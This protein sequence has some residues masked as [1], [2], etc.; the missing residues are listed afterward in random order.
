MFGG[1]GGGWA[2]YGTTLVWLVAAAVLPFGGVRAWAAGLRSAGKGGKQVV[3]YVFPRDR[4]LGSEEVSATGLTRVNYAFANIRDG[5][6]VEGFANDGANYA[7][8]RAL[9]KK[10]PALEV[11]PSVGGW[12]WSGQFSDVALTRES[13]AKFID[14]VV[15]FL[16]RYG[17]D[18][19]DI[20]WEYPGQ[21]GAGNVFRPEDKHN[22]TLLLR[23]L[24][25]RFEVEGRRRHRRHLIL[26]IATGSGPSWLENTEMRE[27]QRYVDSIN[28]MTYDMYGP[29]DKTTGHDSP[30]FVNPAD[31]KGERADAVDRS[32]KLYEA[33][34]VAAR[35]I[36]VGV[37]FYSKRWHGVPAAEQGLYQAV[38]RDAEAPAGGGSEA[39]RGGYL[40][41][42]D[43]MNVGYVRYWDDVAK[44]PYLYSASGRTWI[45]YEDTESLLLKAEFVRAHGLG[46]MMFWEYTSDPSGMLLHAVDVGLRMPT[47]S[48]RR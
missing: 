23:E 27:V 12:A 13:R 3:G 11:V 37:P 48:G 2:L 10:N 36:V 1:R 43:L 46:G 44:A 26:S 15:V 6:M 22:Y 16:N 24:R 42:M 34:G 17:L 18:G 39:A 35:K 19:L 29:E 33:A 14:S 5:L 8:L 38:V 45:T 7:V 32:V 30:L 9:K 20:D 4:V 41:L 47:G 28:L 40:E 21:A 31:P 25:R